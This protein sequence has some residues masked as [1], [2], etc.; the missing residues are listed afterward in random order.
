MRLRALSLALLAAL[1]VPACASRSGPKSGGAVNT[2]TAAD[3]GRTVR[4]TPGSSLEVSL[5]AGWRLSDY[6]RRFLRITTRRDRRGTYTFTAT[7][8]GSGSVVLLDLRRCRR[9]Q[10]SIRSG[11]PIRCAPKPG[12]SRIRRFTFRVSVS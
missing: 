2:V 11:M 1:L 8:T 9:P 4:L 3:E 6:P 5:G 12:V 10:S 7:S